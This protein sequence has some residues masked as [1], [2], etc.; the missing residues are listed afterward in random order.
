MGFFIS[1]IGG[2]G[3]KCPPLLGPEYAPRLCNQSLGRHTAQPNA[4]LKINRHKNRF[5]FLKRTFSAGI[6]N[7]DTSL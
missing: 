6:G 3:G 1:E 7:H 4:N 2:G 5:N